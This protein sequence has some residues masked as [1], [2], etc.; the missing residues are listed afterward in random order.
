MT[1]MGI[2]LLLSSINRGLSIR[3]YRKQGSLYSANSHTVASQITSSNIT[4][5][6]RQLIKIFNVS[7]NLSS[8]FSATSRGISLSS[9]QPINIPIGLFLPLLGLTWNIELSFCFVEMGW[10]PIRIP[11]T[12]RFSPIYELSV[13]MVEMGW[14]PIQNFG[15]L[16]FQS[17]FWLIS[18]N[19]LSNEN[20][21]RI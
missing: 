4:R 5:T 10:F 16:F 13:Q 2:N 9:F 11:D 20:S 12:F 17:E 8:W 19:G 18:P 6:K 3:H 7:R 1:Y 14:F 21:R 15:Q